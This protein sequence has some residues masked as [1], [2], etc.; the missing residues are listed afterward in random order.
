MSEVQCCTWHTATEVVRQ[1]SGIVCYTCRHSKDRRLW[2]IYWIPVVVVKGHVFVKSMLGWIYL[3]GEV[4]HA[5]EVGF[6]S[7]T[8][9]KPVY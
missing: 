2:K 4:F 9:T 5:H 8:D 6:F 3:Q 7:S 1:G